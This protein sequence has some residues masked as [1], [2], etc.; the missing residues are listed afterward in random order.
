MSARGQWLAL[1]VTGRDVDKARKRNLPE[2]LETARKRGVSPLS[3]ARCVGRL[4]NYRTTF[5]I[6]EYV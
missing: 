6:R 2:A 3:G 1:A 5:S 4:D